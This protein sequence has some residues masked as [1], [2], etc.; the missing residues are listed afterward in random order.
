MPTLGIDP[1]IPE[2][3]PQAQTGAVAQRLGLGDL[4]DDQASREA[5]VR[6]TMGDSIADRYG[7][8]LGIRPRGFRDF[9]RDFA[10][11]N[12]SQDP[13]KS[14]ELR[15]NVLNS[16][17]KRYEQQLEEGRRLRREAAQK[18]TAFVDLVERAPK[19]K[20]PVPLRANYIFQRAEQIGRPVTKEVA[21]FIAEGQIPPEVLSMPEFTQALDEDPMAAADMLV[22][23]GSD[24]TTAVDTVEQL[25]K[26]KQSKQNAARRTESLTD[27]LLRQ[28]ERK[29]RIRTGKLRERKLRLDLKK[30]KEADPIDT[31][32][33]DALGGG[34]AA[35]TG[36][37]DA[38]AQ[39]LGIE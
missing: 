15:T 27:A 9:L 6:E 35:P 20:L 12:A 37:V 33:S 38:A 1:A 19:L 39:R 16:F 5:V 24:F 11:N 7:D 21:K 4:L 32:I 26:L 13:A 28:R 17:T 30:G 29:L 2:D 23:F 10:I 22:Q 3:V 31:L 8:T 14:Q 18:N 25:Q 36:D 34:A